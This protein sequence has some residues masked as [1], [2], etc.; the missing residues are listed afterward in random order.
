FPANAS[1]ALTEPVTYDN[2][3]SCAFYANCTTQAGFFET[4]SSEI[5]PIKGLKMG[6]TP[7][8]SFLSST[9]E[10]FYDSSCINLI[11]TTIKNITIMNTT[12]VTELLHTNSSRF[13]PN[14]TIIDLV[15]ELLIETW[16]TTMNYSAYFDYCLPTSCSYTYIQQLSSLYTVTLLLGLYGGLSV[17]LKWICPKIIYIL[18]NIYW[19][20]KKQSN[21][22]TFAH[23]TEVVVIEATSAA[24]ASINHQNTTVHSESESTVSTPQT[25]S[26]LVLL[27]SMFIGI[28]VLMVVAVALIGPF[29]YFSRQGKNQAI[30]I[31]PSCQLTFQF[32]PLFTIIYGTLVQSFAVDDFNSDSHLDLAIPNL[33]TNSVDIFLGTGDGTFRAAN[34]FSTGEGNS[35]IAVTVGD[36]NNDNQIDL[37]VENSDSDNIGVMLGNN[38]GTFREQMTFS[39]EYNSRPS[40]IIVNDFNNDNQL[41]LAFI[42][43]DG[44]KIGILLG[45]G[46]GI[47]RPILTALIGSPY[48]AQ[49]AAAADFNDD[50]HQDLVINAYQNA[51][52]ILFGNGDGTFSAQIILSTGQFSGSGSIATADFNGDNRTDLAIVNSYNFNVGIMLANGNGTFAEQIKYSTGSYSLPVSVVIGDFNNDH[53]LDLAIANYN[54]HN[55]GVMFGTS[56]GSFLKQMTFSVGVKS[57][58][59]TIAIGD[60]NNDSKL[61]IVIIDGFNNTV[62]ILLN[63]CNCC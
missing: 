3:C 27:R 14:T 36:F 48:V 55:I 44:S 63:T 52:N 60:F 49:S 34:T 62:G 51:V 46:D 28:L 7:S 29:A 10:C 2:D 20:R 23:T 54:T 1:L 30:E 47:F 22:V 11:E 17:I 5:I 42:Y 32:V 24:N 35:P 59:G 21:R 45:E 13:V 56:N 19:Y 33:D 37:V 40:D 61:D 41:D 38:D 9:L 43:N 8:E 50:G 6:C 25:M 58:P 57:H 31:M 4:N 53:Q 15:N 16:L 18:F 12:Y 26:Y 39:T